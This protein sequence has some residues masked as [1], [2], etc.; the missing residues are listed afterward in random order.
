MTMKTSSLDSRPLQS[1]LSPAQP[2]R[3][4]ADP[5]TEVRKDGK[6]AG[7]YNAHLHRQ[8]V[9]EPGEGT[10]EVDNTTYT[11][12]TRKTFTAEHSLVDRGANGFVRGSDCVLIGKPVL[13]RHVNITGIDNHQLNHIPIATV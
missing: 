10:S 5:S 6:Y 2:Q 7:Y 8:G 9:D 11:V 4:M 12:S 13:Q 3:M 1:A